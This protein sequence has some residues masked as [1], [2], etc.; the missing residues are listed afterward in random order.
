[1]LDV[2]LGRPHDELTAHHPLPQGSPRTKIVVALYQGSHMVI[3]R[4]VPMSAAKV[5]ATVYA[6]LGLVIGAIV[7]LIGFAGGYGSEMRG[8][9]GPM[10]GIGAIILLPLVYGAIG[11]IAVLIV[12]WLYN[13]AAGITGGI[14]IQTDSAEP[15]G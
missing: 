15:L 1:M 11:F 3:R 8:V 5:M 12:C 9:M 7:S 2:D 14:E 10:F 13:W 4:I 6:I